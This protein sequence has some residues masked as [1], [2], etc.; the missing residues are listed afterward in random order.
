MLALYALPLL[1][2]LAQPAPS[3]APQPNAR[4]R[5]RRTLPTPAPVADRDDDPG[6][7]DAEPGAAAPSAR[8]TRSR[9]IVAPPPAPPGAPRIVEIALNDKVL[10]K[11]GMLLVRVTTSPDVTTW[12]R[13]RW[14]ARSRSRRPRRAVSPARSS[15][16][17]GSRS[18]CSTATYQIEFVAT[19]ADGRKTGYTLPVRLER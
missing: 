1:L 9:Y 16:R 7:A 5:P 8:R 2:A 12:S 13:G 19:T 18:S 17:A 14:A 11:G 4:R 6:A 3:P 10:H 15:C